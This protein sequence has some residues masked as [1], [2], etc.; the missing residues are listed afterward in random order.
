MTPFIIPLGYAL[1]GFLMKLS[2]DSFDEKQD[3]AFAIFTGIICGVLIGFLSVES[4]DAAYIFFGIFFGTLFARKIDG[5]HHVLTMV[6]FASVILIFGLPEMGIFT[7]LICSI[8]AYLDEIGNDNLKISEKSRFLE[9]FFRYRFTMKIAILVLS[10]L[11][12]WQIVTGATFYGLNVLSPWTVVYF[13][14]FEIAYEIAGHL[15]NGIY[16]KF[17]STSR[18]F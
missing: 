2:D 7:L 11:G 13:I 5:I 8:T 16:D 9:F 17:R 18:V 1:S 14:L 15:F 6:A 12:L 10:L 3:K 4:V